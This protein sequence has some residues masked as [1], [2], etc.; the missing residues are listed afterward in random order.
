MVKPADEVSRVV[1][2]F[3]FEQAIRVGADLQKSVRVALAVTVALW[4]GAAAAQ[5]SGGSSEDL[6]RRVRELEALV[7]TLQA[8][9]NTNAAQAPFSTQSPPPSGRTP[10]APPLGPWHSRPCIAR[11]SC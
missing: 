10:P 1:A 8:Q 5:T 3:V 11:G 7:R 6:E 4:A 2:Q 9:V